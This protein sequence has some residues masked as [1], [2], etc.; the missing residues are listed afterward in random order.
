MAKIIGG[1]VAAIGL[2]SLGAY[3][4]CSSGKASG[5]EEG[6][7]AGIVE[8][9]KVGDTTGYARG[10]AE[11]QA[12]YSATGRFDV[13]T[14]DRLFDPMT[15]R[16]LPITQLDTTV[17]KLRLHPVPVTAPGGRMSV[18]GVDVGAV[19]WEAEII[20]SLKVPQG[21]DATTV[22]YGNDNRRVRLVY[23]DR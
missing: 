15:G 17:G 18:K 8:G 14:Q 5:L 1:A 13:M 3:A 4:G 21:P 7:Q 19:V 9:T 11:M 2:A 10:L 20:D 23:K 22:Q 16:E 6:K 12:K